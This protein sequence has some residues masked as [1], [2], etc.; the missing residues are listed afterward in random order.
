MPYS[1]IA[2]QSFHAR[3]RSSGLIYADGGTEQVLQPDGNLV[4]Y[5]VAD[6]GASG[7][8]GTPGPLAVKCVV[9]WGGAYLS[10]RWRALRG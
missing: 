7:T 6:N 3:G 1:M 5:R 9:S 2:G 8:S 10:L 4:L